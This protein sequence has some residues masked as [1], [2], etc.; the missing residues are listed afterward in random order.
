[1]TNKTIPIITIL[2]VLLTACSG[3]KDNQDCKIDNYNYIEISDLTEFNQDEF[4]GFVYFYR[5]ECP[6][7]EQFSPVLFQQAKEL[8]CPIW[9]TETGKWKD[10]EEFTAIMNEYD[11]TSVPSL[12]YLYGNGKYLKY[13]GPI[14]D[15]DKNCKELR[16]F[17]QIDEKMIEQAQ[18]FV[19]DDIERQT[20]SNGE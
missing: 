19:K 1:M 8:K 3:V 5:E 15:V 20:I 16:S 2:I 4:S 6:F 11:L 13:S 14:V 18:E 17:L 12:Y 9:V 10:N 7:C